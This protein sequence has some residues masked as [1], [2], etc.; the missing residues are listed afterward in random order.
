MAADKDTYFH[1]LLLMFGPDP[2]PNENMIN[3][4]YTA[5]E[6]SVHDFIANHPPVWAHQS[7]ITV[8]K[9]FTQWLG[10]RGLYY[11]KKYYEGKDDGC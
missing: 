10:D 11:R 7:S 5:W 2:N 3:D 9:L 1:A 6:N 4:E 8:L